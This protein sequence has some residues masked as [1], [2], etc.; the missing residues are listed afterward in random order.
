MH[1]FLRL[2]TCAC[3]TAMSLHVCLCLC[4]YVPC[5]WK[6]CVWVSLRGLVIMCSHMFM[7]YTYVH[8]SVTHSRCQMN[9]FWISMLYFNTRCAC[10]TTSG[11][12]G[13]AWGGGVEHAWQCSAGTSLAI[14]GLWARTT[15]MLLFLSKGFTRW[16]HRLLLGLLSGWALSHL[17]PLTGKTI[18]S[19]LPSQSPVVL[20]QPL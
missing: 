18:S 6:V 7:V 20:G 3:Y 10:C 15:L 13:T 17:G 11:L 14:L 12:E 16:C 1:V 2:H 19:G 5:L 4:M 8:R 9:V